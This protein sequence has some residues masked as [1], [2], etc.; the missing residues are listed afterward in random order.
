MCVR[1]T[2]LQLKRPCVWLF[3]LNHW[4]KAGAKHN[5][6]VI[7]I[8]LFTVSITSSRNCCGLNTPRIQPHFYRVTPNICIIDIRRNDCLCWLFLVTVD[9]IRKWLLQVTELPFCTGIELGRCTAPSAVFS[10]PYGKK[11]SFGVLFYG[12]KSKR[13]FRM[14]L[15]HGN[16][17][18]ISHVPILP[19]P[20]VTSSLTSHG[21]VND[22][23]QHFSLNS[24]LVLSFDTIIS[25]LKR[26]WK[27]LRATQCYGNLPFISINV[28]FRKT[29]SLK[30]FPWIF[31]HPNF[32][33]NTIT[34]DVSNGVNVRFVHRIL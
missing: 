30:T 32:M 3:R 20:G 18:N 9:I 24:V 23:T 13:L 15:V 5:N 7:P 2:L 33:T 11:R 31:P 8:W 16:T 4:L 28:C 17:D 34:F 29:V 1:S 14:N 19:W 26:R 6:M 21:S 25:H 22:I 27:V 10:Q 12:F